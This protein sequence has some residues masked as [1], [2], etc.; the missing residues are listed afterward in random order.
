MT[1]R[2]LL[3][4]MLFGG[5]CSLDASHTGEQGGGVRVNQHAATLQDF[6]HRID[7]YMD[8]RGK[9]KA[10]APAL[11][12]TE[13]AAQI[14]AAQDGLAANI[15]AIRA[16]AKPGDIFTPEIR[17]RFRQ[18]MYPELKGEDGRDTRAVLKDDA[19]AAVAL[20]INAPFSA[21]TKPTTP[22]NLLANLPML[23]KELEYRIVDKNLILLDADA[24]L[25]VD[26]IPNAFQ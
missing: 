24:N 3:V 5:A 17:A 21:D 22:S 2:L 6:D 8:L 26:F 15:R 16:D 19:P 4:A 1:L 18:L 14:K 7:G 10:K 25:I 11:R 9:A 13:S 20:K 23:P 12:E